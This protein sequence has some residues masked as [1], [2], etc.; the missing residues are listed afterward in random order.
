[1][2]GRGDIDIIGRGPGVVGFLVYLER[3]LVKIA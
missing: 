2:V 3:F 1:V